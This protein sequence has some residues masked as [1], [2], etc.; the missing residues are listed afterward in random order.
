MLAL[1]EE[2]ARRPVEL[3]HYDT[4]RAVDNECTS[5]SH[6]RDIAQIYVLYLRLK[7]LVLRVA[8]GKA[9]FGLEGN[10]ICH[11]PFK[12]FLYGVLRRID[13]IV[14]EFELVIVPRIFDREDLLENLVK[15]LVTPVLRGSLELEKVL[16]RLQL[17]FKQVRIFKE[18]FRGR[19]RDSLC[20]S[21]F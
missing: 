21:L 20:C 12:A 6:I 15:T 19:E 14:D 3:R 5:W 10:L 11:A 2:H 9:E 4:L 7:V 8:A 1:A 18:N 17:N 16:E 13:E